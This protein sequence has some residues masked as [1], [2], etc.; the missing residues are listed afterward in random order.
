MINTKYKFKLIYLMMVLL[1]LPGI[2]C[3]NEQE[4]TV[5]VEEEIHEMF[6]HLN[7][8]QIDVGG[9][10][11]G[12]ASKRNI[13]TELQVNGI[14]DVPPH[15][16]VSINLPY[17]GFLKDTKMLPGTKVRKGQLIAIIENPDFIEF[18]QEYLERLA[19]QGYLKA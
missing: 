4:V 3:T 7:Q 13:G 1:Y 17:G 9:I 2:S 16:K 11:I 14:I 10:I 5:A 18:Q 8:G 6:V 19:Q 15:S 12:K